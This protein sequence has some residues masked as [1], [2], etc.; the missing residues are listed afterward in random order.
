MSQTSLASPERK[1][2]RD[3]SVEHVKK[4]YG[5]PR[6]P[7]KHRSPMKGRGNKSEVLELSQDMQLLENLANQFSDERIEVQR[8]QTIIQALEQKLQS[9][10]A[11]MSELQKARQLLAKSEADRTELQVHIGETVEAMKQASDENK[12]H[13]E[14]LTAEIERLN[15]VLEQIRAE[16]ASE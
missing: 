9:K 2:E 11:V 13:H 12:A 7:I 4:T 16:L 5:R 3:A 15:A 10:E 1:R 8:Q 14:R 6:S